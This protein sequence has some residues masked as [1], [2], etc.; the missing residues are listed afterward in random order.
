VP[1]TGLWLDAPLAVM[2]ARVSTRGQDA[3]DADAGVVKGQHRQDPGTID[4]HRI[5]ASGL[6]ADVL[7]QARLRCRDD[8][9]AAPDD[10]SQAP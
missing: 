10:T 3:S 9:R 2:V 6:P 7:E 4:W 1:F 5:D 8:G